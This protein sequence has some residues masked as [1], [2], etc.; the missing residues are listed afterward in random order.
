MKDSGGNIGIIAEITKLVG[1]KIS[2][3]AETAVAV[4]STLML[5]GKG[6]VAAVGNVA[7]RMYSSLY[8]FQKR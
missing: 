4:L 6:A 5:G 7:P 8:E 2:A 1:D 3:L